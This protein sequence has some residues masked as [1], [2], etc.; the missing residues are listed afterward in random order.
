M[1]IYENLFVPIAEKIKKK[2]EKKLLNSKNS[3]HT[4]VCQPSSDICAVCVHKCVSLSF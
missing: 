4:V 1:F 3:C 2:I